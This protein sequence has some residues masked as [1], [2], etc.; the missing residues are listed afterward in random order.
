MR[1]ERFKRMHFNIILWV[2][3]IFHFWSV[4]VSKC[5]FEQCIVV[6]RPCNCQIKPLAFECSPQLLVALKPTNDELVN[7][8]FSPDLSKKNMKCVESLKL[9][10]G[11]HRL[12]TPPPALSF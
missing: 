12:K 11:N 3:L 9:L 7:L 2:T 8:L 6:Y 1:D 4:E 5:A 10:K